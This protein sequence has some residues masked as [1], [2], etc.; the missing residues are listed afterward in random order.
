MKID[1]EF[2]RRLERVR[3]F[4]S[5]GQVSSQER[6]FPQDARLDA[7]RGAE[8]ACFGTRIVRS[9]KGFNKKGFSDIDHPADRR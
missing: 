9:A 7:A 1:H 6:A 5:I 8:R 4:V 3:E 2:S